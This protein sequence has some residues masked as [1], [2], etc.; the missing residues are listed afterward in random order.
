[1]AELKEF[2]VKR[3]LRSDGADSGPGYW[4][5]P[6]PSAAKKPV[7]DA[8]ASATRQKA[9]MVRLEDD[10]PRFV[11]WRVK[12]GI[13]LKQE[14]APNPDEGNPW[15]LQFP[16]GYWLYE[17]SKHLWVSGH[18]IKGK[19][20][21]T[22]QEFGLHLLWLM[23]TS[24]DYRDCCCIHCNVPAMKPAVPLETAVPLP[25]PAAP[26]APAAAPPKS[27]PT[28]PHK[29][30][31]VPLPT[32][33][34]QPKPKE[35]VNGP[36]PEKPKQTHV[37]I[38]SPA[39]AHLGQPQAPARTQAQTS[40]LQQAQPQPQPQPQAQ[41]QAQPQPQPQQQVHAQARAANWSLQ[42]PLLFRAGELVWYQNGN[43]WRLGVISA[44]GADRFEVL[45]IGH[46]A[47]TQQSVEKKDREM[48][49]FHA[50]SVP[51]V[52]MP[53]LQGKPFD[54]T[55]WVEMFNYAGQ[56]RVKRNNMLLD[57]SKMAASKIDASYSF[58]S[59]LSQDMQAE[60]V[61]FY[62]CFLGAERIELG[63]CLRVNAVAGDSVSW[64]DSSVLGVRRIILRTSNRQ[65]SIVLV[66]TIY[67]IAKA[68]DPFAQ[69]VPVEDLPVPLQEETRWRNA[70][71]PEQPWRW[72][73]VKEDVVLEE[74]S[75][76]GRFYPT[77]HIMPIL[78][79]ATF[80][81]AVA[82]R[83]VDSQYPYLNNRLDGAGTYIGFC[84]N[85]RE[86]LGASVAPAARLRL[87]SMVREMERAG[88][89]QAAAL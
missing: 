73:L 49:P 19:L 81:A 2:E 87:E 55:P 34:G 82:E 27:T 74:R 71:N 63:D 70:V 48:R 58:W 89:N 6:A 78:N 50:F 3:I 21:K 24:A 40:Q 9:H 31:P 14:L 10:D 56:D 28:I 45:P 8:P 5:A 23:S 54:A 12:L 80:N 20:Y 85:R 59:P 64:N 35:P 53:E 7:K 15:Y 69:P 72:S 60:T 38:P 68:N 62:G 65:R 13:L 32:F 77:H 43:S 79:E 18:P 75:I 25:T 17:K 42:S 46:E 16:R 57:A 84:Y 11:D 41:P 37:P 26:A 33:P 67:Q 51:G 61:P 66:G 30:T 83:N 4:P 88:G 29:V 36:A 52:S 47:M 76:R 86:A 22:P 44:P 39:G 1:M